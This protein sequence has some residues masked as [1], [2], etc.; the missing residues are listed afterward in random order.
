M[1]KLSTTLSSINTHSFEISEEVA[2]SKQQSSGIVNELL[3][4]AYPDIF[5]KKKGTKTN[6][7]NIWSKVIA[8]APRKYSRSWGKL[9]VQLDRLI[10]LLYPNENTSEVMFTSFRKPLRD[11]KYDNE[12]YK[13]SVYQLGVD[14]QRSKQRKEEYAN[15]VKARNVERGSLVPLYVEQIYQTV[16]QLIASNNV[17]EKLVAVELATGSRSIEVLKVSQYEEVK[18]NP[19]E[20]LVIGLAK[21][22]GQNNLEN[23][24]LTRNLVRLKAKQVISAVTYIRSKVNTE[25]TND[26]ISSRTNA[27]LNKV[28][29]QVFVPILKQ[30]AGDKA[31]TDEFKKQLKSFTSHKARYIAGNVSFLEYGKHKKIPYESYLQQQYGHLSGES[32]KSY[33]AINIKFKSKTVEKGDTEELKQLFNSEIGD[34]RTQLDKCCAKETDTLDVAPFKNSF[35]KG[36]DEY[37]KVNN[38]VE[39]IKLYKK[40]EVKI[41]QKDLRAKLGYSADIMTKAYKKFRTL[42]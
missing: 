13:Q 16:D 30:N 24:R 5:D 11:A 39:A 33:L 2:Q 12:I 27:H 32:T 26:A 42:G 31:D 37:A 40:N 21:D 36:E 20:I 6:L 19:N 38:V 29:K 34:L 9:F 23:V 22:K 4:Q 1:N 25:G 15:R 28:F 14:Q 17:Y 3:E 7:F 18:D 41:T 10:K 8:T 35:S